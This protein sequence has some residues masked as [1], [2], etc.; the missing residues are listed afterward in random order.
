[1]ALK[2]VLGIALGHNVNQLFC[3][4][5]QPAMASVHNFEVILFVLDGTTLE[6]HGHRLNISPVYGHQTPAIVQPSSIVLVVFI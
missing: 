4:V 3:S 2:L 5:M 1:M 6:H